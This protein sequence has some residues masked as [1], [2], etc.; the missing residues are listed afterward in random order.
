MAV[1]KQGKVKRSGYREETNHGKIVTRNPVPYV[2]D[3][4][5][6]YYFHLGRRALFL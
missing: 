3:R 4:I 6:C 5:A 2:W 1:I